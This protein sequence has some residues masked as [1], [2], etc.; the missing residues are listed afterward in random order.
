MKGDTFLRMKK[1][2]QQEQQIYIVDQDEESNTSSVSFLD[3]LRVLFGRKILLLIVT[4]SLFAL[5]TL[6]ILLV[7]NS[8]STYVATFDY[9]TQNFSNGTYLDGSHFD[10][11]DSITLAKLNQYKN[12]HNELKKLNMEKVLDGNGIVSLTRE[13]RYEENKEKQSE[14][15]SNYIKI[16]EGYKIVLKNAHF[17]GT[18]ARVLVEAIAND[19]LVVSKSI[20]DNSNYAQFLTFYEKSAIYD[21][22]ID[23]LDQQYRLLDSKYNNLLTIYGD[24]T[25]SNGQKVSD[26][27][28]ALKDYFQSEAFV[29]EV[30]EEK[31][32]NDK[33]EVV[34]KGQSILLASLKSELDI[35]GYV[36][37]YDG[38]SMQLEKQVDSLTRE[39]NVTDAKKQELVNQRD[40]LLNASGNLNTIEIAAYNDAIIELSNKVIDLNDQITLINL[41][42][43]NKG[44]EDIDDDYAK[45]LKAFDTKLQKC[46][47]SLKEMTE[48]YQEIE[49]EVVD[50]KTVTYFKSNSV[51]EKENALK[52]YL[53]IPLALV[54]SFVVALFVNLCV[55]GKKLSAKYR[56]QEA[57]AAK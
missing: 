52:I 31:K 16:D 41:K 45:D 46:Y 15:D 42:I 38:Y 54:G 8:L 49:K 29:T 55:D 11:R 43:N 23:Y 13:I 56:E 39:K 17:S 24:T 32:N 40:A 21:R 26:A 28:I 34:D 44:R 6:A 48:E 4:A 5:S 19:A 51:V 35:N 30:K 22:Q 53:F 18:E 20:A 25:L 3:F 57:K 33:E 27:R 10:I 2:E 9:N 37:D 36:K 7:N 47:T 1:D 12:E 50:N 14:E